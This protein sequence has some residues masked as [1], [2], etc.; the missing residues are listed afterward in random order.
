MTDPITMLRELPAPELDFDATS[1][2]ARIDAPRRRR[3]PLVALAATAA[4]AAAVV[5]TT[6]G[7]PTATRPETASALLRDLAQR[8]G[9]QPSIALGPGQYRFSRIVQRNA[10]NHEKALELRY[11]ENAAGKGR[12]VAILDGKTL[13]DTYL[14]APHPGL[15][16]GPEPPRL[17]RLPTEPAALA[18]RMEELA[19]LT[20][21]PG[22]EREP[23]ARHY[24]LAATQMVTDPSATPPEVLRAI[25]TFLS[26]QPG[27]RLIGDV[28]DPLGRPG[29]A[30]AVDGD[31]DHEGIG[32]ELIVNP[33][34][35]SPLAFV[36]Y[37]D[38]DVHRPWLEL[39]REVAVVDGDRAVSPT[40]ASARRG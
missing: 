21:V 15:P 5:L 29:K 25:F 26:E 10:E 2:H 27:I 19:R 6:G 4:V 11:W 39:T 36:H 8:A 31:P 3:A 17:D 16:E 37:K 38:G 28:V 32:V 30:V 20:M 34:T 23:T 18:A 33:E 7:S 40:S 22:G 14:G 12:E 13:R 9:E 1:T 24:L 35:G